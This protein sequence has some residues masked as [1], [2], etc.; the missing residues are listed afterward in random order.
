[1]L[2]RC[3][4]GKA[5][6]QLRRALVVEREARRGLKLQGGEEQGGRGVP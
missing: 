6:C 1:M 2:P 4:S 5:A 3:Y